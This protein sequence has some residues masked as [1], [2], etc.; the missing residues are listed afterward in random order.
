MVRDWIK[1]NNS[2]MPNYA[3]YMT[4]KEWLE[5]EHILESEFVFIIMPENVDI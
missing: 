4:K 1:Y 3:N 5:S 2:D